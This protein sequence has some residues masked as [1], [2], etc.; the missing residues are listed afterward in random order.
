MTQRDL[1]RAIR[2]I[3][4]SAFEPES[5]TAYVGMPD[6]EV[7]V[8]PM[9]NIIPNEKGEMPAIFLGCTF[10]KSETE[11]TIEKGEFNPMDESLADNSFKIIAWLG[12]GI[13]IGLIL[14]GAIFLTTY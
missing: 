12:I 4:N 7:K 2:V 11:P 14:A 6:G 10:S 13:F 9:H 5:H 1:D 3:E 8:L